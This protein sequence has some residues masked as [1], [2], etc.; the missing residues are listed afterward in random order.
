M[1]GRG[2]VQQLQSNLNPDIAACGRKTVRKWRKV[3]L[4]RLACGHRRA[5]AGWWAGAH[6]SKVVWGLEGAHG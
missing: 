4:A 6:A 2:V 1:C 3:G 5:L